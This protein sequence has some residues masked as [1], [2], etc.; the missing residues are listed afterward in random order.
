MRDRDTGAV[1]RVAN[2]RRGGWPGT[3]LRALVV[4]GLVGALLAGAAAFGAYAWYARDLPRLDR[5][6]DLVSPGVTRFEAG[7][8]QVVGEWY[9]QRRI[10][11]DWDQLPRKLVLAFLAAEDARFFFHE[12]VDLKGIVR[13]M[14]TN[15]RA[16]EI[17][18]GASTITQQLAKALVGHDKSYERKIREAILARRMEDIY[19]KQQI[20]TW[21]LNAIYLGHGSYGVQAAAQNYFR[22]DVWD[23]DLA[24]VA[25]IG[26]LPQSP[27]R[28]N[29]A[30]DMP[31]ARRRMGHV[32]D[33]M[34]RRGWITADEREAALSTDLEVHPI[35]D[36]L[37]DHVPYY[38]E[39]VRKRIVDRYGEDGE[40]RSWLD[41]GLRVSMAVD[42]ATQRV[43]SEALGAALEDL[44][45][46]QGFP[47]PLGRMERDDFLARSAPYL[48]AGGVS[49]GDRLLGRVTKAG[50]E[51][52]TVELADGVAGTLR[53]KDTRWAGPYTEFPVKGGRRITSGRVSFEPRLGAM[54]DA[55]S[56]GDV[57]YVEVGG[58]KRDAPS[59]E[60]VPIPLMEGA[61]VSYPTAGGGLDALVG[62]WDFDRS[63]VNRAFSV[64][65]TGSTMKPIVYSKAYDLGLPPSAL[66]SGAPFREGDYNPT[67]KRTKDD[68]LVWDALAKS[69]NSVSLRVLQYV[70]HH[71][72]RD[73]YQAWGRALGLPRQL[74]GFTSEVLGADQTPFG[75]AHAFGVF[76][77]RGLDPTMGLV[78]KVVDDS[79]RVLERHVHPLDRHAPLHDVILAAWDR[80]LRPAERRIAP[81]TAYLTGANLVEVVER[82]TGRRARRLERE[83]AGKTGTL[84][85]DVWFDGFSRERVAVVWIG[86]DRRERPLG[87]S[88]DVNRVYGSDTALPAWLAF[89]ERVGAGRPHRSIVREP[90]PDIVRVR[91]DPD[92]GLLAR[93]GGREIPH[94]EGTAPTEFGWE[95]ES[96]QNIHETETEF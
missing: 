30:V 83:V 45:K 77:R 68:M 69:E 85:Y 61:F 19:T 62:G 96:P 56:P 16:G 41:L 93:D 87:L 74:E 92:T 32:L 66:F 29:P 25:M 17:R 75:M 54:N 18:E 90:P 4:V 12:G 8:G 58:G 13:A 40:G 65:Q 79:G 24:E 67:G 76:A 38:T 1:V 46:R 80:A 23:L 63:Q 39:E 5:F 64:R 10:Q 37:G 21:Y 47:G 42:P 15:I 9:Q 49:E 31:A 55:L 26:G 94:R 95:P 48:P 78:R 57:V 73:D 20:L 27:G 81:R 71:T 33:Q 84:P 34:H 28:V 11:L 7:D 91:V 53:L 2:R 89:M 44:A 72:S 60:M 50:E 52:A 14:I 82:G 3:A 6:D 70:L 59:L 51:T 22:K 86:A 36:T 88:E 43:A 35:R